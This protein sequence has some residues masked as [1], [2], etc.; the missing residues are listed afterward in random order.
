MDTARDFIPH[1]RYYPDDSA[2][3]VRRLADA[4]CPACSAA[5]SVPAKLYGGTERVI[6]WL[7]DQLVE[8]GHDV[9]MFASG[10]SKTRGKLHPV[11]P[12]AQRFGPE[13]G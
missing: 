9:T 12:R 11:W 13:A 2:A 8:I 5:E 4:D 6:A 10:D 1:I 3:R 7:V